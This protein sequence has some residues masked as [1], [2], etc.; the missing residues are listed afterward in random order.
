MKDAFPVYSSQSV[1]RVTSAL[2]QRLALLAALAYLPI[3]ALANT[4]TPE[5]TNAVLNVPGTFATI[6]AAVN[7]SAAGDEI[8]IGNG[9]YNE[10]VNLNTAGGDIT[11]RAANPGMVTVNGGTSRAFSVTGF[12]GNVTIDGLVLTSTMNNSTSGVISSI[13]LTGRL[14]VSNCTFSPTATQFLTD[15]IYCFS[16]VNNVPTQVRRPVRFIELM[17]PE[18]ELFMVEV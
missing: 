1:N 10:S 17:T 15:G 2:I 13:N 14:T 3:F 16:D 4:C 9:T 7:A 6:Q 5:H 18:V 8:V 11:I 12:T